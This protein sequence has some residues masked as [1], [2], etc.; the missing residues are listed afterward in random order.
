[1]LVTTKKEVTVTITLSETEAYVL[2]AMMQS[3]AC[4]PSDE[5]IDVADLR[6]GLLNELKNV[7]TGKR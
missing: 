3:P 7:L 6:Q 1:M 5:S 4:N 2:K